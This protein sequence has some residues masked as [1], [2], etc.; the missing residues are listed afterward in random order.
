[1]ANTYTQIYIHGVFAVRFRQC[2]LF[3]SY[4]E[5]ARK[6]MSGIV[7]NLES[8]L[9]SINTMP[10]HC[11]LLIGLNPTMSISELLGKVKSGS[12]KYIN[13]KRFVHG[14][15]EWQDG[16][17]AF[18]YSRSQLSNV[19]TY[20]ENQ[21]IHHKKQSFRKEYIELLDTFE[22]EYD[23]RYIFRALE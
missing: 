6:Y 9:I 7:T 2:L 19:I 15:F 13:S 5:K 10:D 23:K 21:Q 22:I 17:G 16:F 20:I 3:D 11:H 18:S 14:R 1:M 8:K 12:S 4:A